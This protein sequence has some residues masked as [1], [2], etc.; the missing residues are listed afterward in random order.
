MLITPLQMLSSLFATGAA[1]EFRHC[2]PLMPLRYC[3]FHA[4]L[5]AYDTYGAMPPLALDADDVTRH[6]TT[7]QMAVHAAMR[8]YV[9]RRCR[10]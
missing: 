1:F 6:V 3:H 9:F 7:A 10:C 8:Y 5:Y 2:M 4:M